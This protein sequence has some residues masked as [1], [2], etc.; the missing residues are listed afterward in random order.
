LIVSSDGSRRSLRFVRGQVALLQLQSACVYSA[1]A[2]CRPVCSLLHA[3]ITIQM[4]MHCCCIVSNALAAG[5]DYMH[6]TCN[7]VTH[8]L[9]PTP[10]EIAEARYL[11]LFQFIDLT[12]DFFYSYTYDLTNSLQ[13]N[14]TAATS[15]TFPPPP[16]KVR[17]TL[18]C[19]VHT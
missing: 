12:K 2:Q 3:F 17:C 14:M 16:F 15:K 8:K 18:Q 9:N 1:Y 13:H 5:Y 6:V 4:L 19:T 7:Q 11:S 10:R